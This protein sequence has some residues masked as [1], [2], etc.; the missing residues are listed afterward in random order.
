ML[1]NCVET[2]KQRGGIRWL[3]DT[4]VESVTRAGFSLVL[5]EEGVVVVSKGGGVMRCVRPP[6]CRGQEFSL[7]GHSGVPLTKRRSTILLGGGLE[8]YFYF[9]CLR[10]Y[11]F[12]PSPPPFSLPLGKFASHLAGLPFLVSPSSLYLSQALPPTTLLY[13]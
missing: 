5:S 7:Q 6:S 12:L 13:S 1:V 8:F 3:V 2:A 4:S 10:W 11:L 9:S